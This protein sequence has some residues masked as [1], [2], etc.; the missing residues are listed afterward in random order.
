MNKKTLEL[1]CIY[2]EKQM[3]LEE[4]TF[5]ISSHVKM[6]IVEGKFWVVTIKLVERIKR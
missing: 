4:F 2:V 3:I 6:I 1:S 5:V